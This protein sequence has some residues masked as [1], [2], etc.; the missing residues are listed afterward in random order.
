MMSHAR[1]SRMEE[2]HCDKMLTGSFNLLTN[3]Q[4][5]RL[6]DQRVTFPLLPG[7][8]GSSAGHQDGV[9][10]KA[11]PDPAVTPQVGPIL[12]SKSTPSPVP[13]SAALFC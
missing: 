5:H 13:Q 2:Q 8:H 6:D 12:T 7:I 1:D 10:T 3:T 11:G 9:K 4:G